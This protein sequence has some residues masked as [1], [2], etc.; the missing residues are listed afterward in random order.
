MRNSR[1]LLESVWA[2]QGPGAQW[3]KDVE[4]LVETAGYCMC[5]M[6][7]S[8]SVWGHLLGGSLGFGC[9]AVL[10]QRCS[11][12]LLRLCFMQSV[13]VDPG[14][15]LPTVL[16]VGV[17]AAVGAYRVSFAILAEYFPKALA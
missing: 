6:G 11:W 12:R 10:G 16:P 1:I 8:R 13:R 3:R 15:P 9:K 2:S 17:V 14:L 7:R 4:G 5:A